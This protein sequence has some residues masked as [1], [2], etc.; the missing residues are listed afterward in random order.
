MAGRPKHR[1]FMQRLEAAGGDA[2]LL[3]R[4]ANGEYISDLAVEL[5]VAL[6]T[7][8]YYLNHK[9][10]REEY[11]HA[12]KIAAQTHAETG[13][14]V[15]DSAT[16][17]TAQVARLRSDYRRWLAERL[18]PDM[19]DRRADSEGATVN[20][21]TLHLDALR[22][23]PAIAAQGDAQRVEEDDDDGSG[24]LG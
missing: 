24:W 2:W 21:G 22:Q 18:D 20:I 23:A 14:R 1:E 19:W 7:L 17:Q 3:E 13:Q 5:Q 9:D 4:V 10:R 15:V 6:P 16:V 8:S 11:R 12:R